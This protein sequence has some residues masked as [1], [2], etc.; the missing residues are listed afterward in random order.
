[1]SEAAAL[2]SEAFG[3]GPDAVAVAPGRIN[4]I[5]EH[6][7]YNGGFVLPMALDQRTAVAVSRTGD[8]EVAVVSS[9]A[10]GEPVR[11]PATTVPGE[12]SGW[13]AYVAGVVWSLRR[14]G[15]P[16]DGARVAVASTVPVGAGLSSSAALEAAVAVALADPARE[17]ADLVRVANDAE[18]H[19]VGVPC[20]VMDQTVVLTARAGHALLLDADTLDTRH[21][22]LRLSAHG[23]ALLAVDTRVS[24]RLSDGGYAT[25]RRECEAAAAV[26][27]VRTLR[28]ADLASIDDPALPDLLRGR[29]RHVM[30]E[31]ARVLEVARL[32]EGGADPRLVGP[33]LTAS[34][35]SMRDDFAITVPEV[36]TAAAATL[37]AGAYGA[38]M[39]GGGFGGCVIALVE[40]TALGSV[41]DAVCA[42]FQRAGFA[43]PGMFE[44]APSAGA[45]RL[46]AGAA[47]PGG[48][49]SA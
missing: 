28:E 12:V 32:L 48:R 43:P 17:P 26:L 44:A 1:V 31:N 2:L 46:L 20:G 15:H 8:G 23:L 45:E 21:I 39:T 16:V 11:F 36:D 25:R 27:G 42:A 4:L 3:V 33:L 14:A 38:R 13:A 34:H 24:R 40:T 5:G 7:D 22:P 10:A 47:G 19:Y 35:A 30:T 29:V 49:G 6:T 18:V 9:A 41:G 37:D